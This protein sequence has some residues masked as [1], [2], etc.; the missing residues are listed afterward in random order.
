[1]YGEK[2]QA[3]ERTHGLISG[4]MAQEMGCEVK[5]ER[6]LG[7]DVQLLSQ[8]IDRLDDELG[9][10]ADRVRPVLRSRGK[11]STDPEMAKQ[12]PE[13]SS[14]V[15]AILIEA[16]RRIDFMASRTVRLRNDIAL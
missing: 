15:S 8:A 5:R 13:P 16:A 10:L 1:M 7:D 9:L 2:N 4:A 6:I 11:E 14:D 12:S 3:I